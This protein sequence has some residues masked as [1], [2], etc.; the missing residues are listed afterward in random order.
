[1]HAQPGRFEDRAHEGDGRALAVGS[2]DMDD[3]RKLAFRMA[4]RRQQPPHPIERKID[5][6]GM[7]RQQTLDDGIDG[8]W[9]RVYRFTGARRSTLMRSPA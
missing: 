1:M 8:S 6:L 2:G 3:R 4:E 9:R 5:Q 7:Q